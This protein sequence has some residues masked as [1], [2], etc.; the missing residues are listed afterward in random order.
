MSNSLVKDTTYDASLH[1]VVPAVPYVPGVGARTVYET[2]VVC[3]FRY[4]VPGRYVYATDPV[5]NQTRV[6][7]VPDVPSSIGGSSGI[8]RCQEA[9]V[10]VQYPA[11]PVQL[12]QPPIYALNYV[13][14]LNLGFNAGAR[15][16]EFFT[17]DGYITFQ[18]RESVVGVICGLNVYDGLDSR[19]SG[20]TTDYGFYL[21]RGIAFTIESGTIKGVAGAYTSDTVFKVSRVGT[22]ITYDMDA[23]TVRIAEDASTDAARMEAALY[24]AGD[25]VFNPTLVAVSP[26][27]TSTKDATLDLVLPPLEMLLAD[28]PYAEMR[29]TLPDLRPDFTTGFVVPDYSV[30]S[31]TLPPLSTM[32]NCLT[33]EVAALDVELPPLRQLW[34]DHPYAEMDLTL[35]PLDAILDATEGPGSASMS[36]VVSAV[37][38]WTA[39]KVLLVTMTSTGV[40]AGIMTSEVVLDARMDSSAA[41]SSIFSLASVQEAIMRSVAT[42][43]ALTGVPESEFQTW[44]F[45]MDSKGS[46]TY[47]NF[48]F[49]S[50]ARIGDQYYGASES[51]LFALD[52]DTDVGEPIRGVIGL[53]QRNFGTSAKKTVVDCYVGMSGE[54]RLVLKVIAEGQ[55]YLYRTRSFSD[56]MQQQKI[57]LGKGLRT[58]YVT[59]ELF[60]EEGQDFEIDAVEFL[61]ADLTRRI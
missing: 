31:I 17:E 20:S 35:P 22:S 37:T 51:G 11:T 16:L 3:G 2:R 56:Q 39:A 38:P 49:N 23:S 60:N 13:P 30:L 32:V 21:S 10:P 29:V 8:Y 52:G 53:G 14:N 19:Y 6:T 46:T 4:N 5:T 47:S 61:V 15:S 12:A 50:Y 59:L 25:E 45:N 28:G 41:L 43:S 40:V 7:F 54:G 36:S 18:V 24:S 58:N 55:P 34:A 44:V 48:G 1:V 27:D 26:P 9:L 42:A 33:G 57:D